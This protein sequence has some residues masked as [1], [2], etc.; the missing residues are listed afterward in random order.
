MQLELEMALTLYERIYERKF[1]CYF[2][3]LQELNSFKVL[4]KEII[5]RIIDLVMS[6]DLVCGIVR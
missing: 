6:A 4:P 2:D 5:K 3:I 1:E